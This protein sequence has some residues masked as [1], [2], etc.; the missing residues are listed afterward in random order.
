MSFPG[1]VA[2]FAWCLRCERVYPAIL[3]AE[4]DWECP[5]PNCDGG[6]DDAWAWTPGCRLLIEHPEYPEVPEPGETYPL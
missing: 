4:N 2:A 1:F 6:P 3:W 5:N